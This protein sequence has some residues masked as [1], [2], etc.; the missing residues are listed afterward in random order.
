MWFS[1]SPNK[2]FIVVEVASGSETP[3][4]LS[5]IS[6]LAHEFFHLILRE[7]KNLFSQINKIAKENK[8]NTYQIVNRN[9]PSNVFRRTINKFIHS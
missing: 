8:K 4:R 2:S 5:A 6:I 9:T 3:N 1:W 7:N